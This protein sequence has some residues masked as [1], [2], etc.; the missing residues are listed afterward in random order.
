MQD[1]SELKG[2]AIQIAAQLPNDVEAAMAILSFAKDLVEWRAGR[3]AM[4]RRADQP[5]AGVFALR[6]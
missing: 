2:L 3:V 4:L 1:P 6:P 5:S